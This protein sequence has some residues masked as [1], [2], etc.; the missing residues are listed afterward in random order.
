MVK[1]ARSE[2]DVAARLHLFDHRVLEELYDV[3]QDPDCLNNLIADAGHQQALDQVRNQL[4]ED[5]RRI[6]EPVAKLLAD[7][8]NVALRESFM[9]AED[10]KRL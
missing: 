7:R 1:R 5:L 8:E 3:Q 6:E 10:A 4:L 9:A 2:P